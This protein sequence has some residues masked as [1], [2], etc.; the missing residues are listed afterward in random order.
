[1]KKQQNKH[2]GSD[3]DDFLREEGLYEDVC[4]AAAKRVIATQI[5]EALAAQRKSV[6][7]LAREM[8][9]SRAVVL[10]LLDEK[11]QSLSL[12]TLAKAATVLG[13]RLRLEL[14]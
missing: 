4:A 12:K 5:A 2:R 9:T 3:F 14:A 7:Q 8:N 11:N 10:R 13:K 1:M 6:S